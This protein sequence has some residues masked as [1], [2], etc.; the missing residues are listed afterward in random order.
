MKV[1]VHVNMCTLKGLPMGNSYLK[2]FIVG[3]VSCDICCFIT[4]FR[5]STSGQ[6]LWLGCF[7]S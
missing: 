7:W 5:A 4:P 1:Y 3:I 6:L 2:L